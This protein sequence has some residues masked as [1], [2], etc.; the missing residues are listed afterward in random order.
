[1]VSF[2]WQLDIFS[3]HALKS[4]YELEVSAD[5]WRYTKDKPSL[6][7]EATPAFLTLFLLLILLQMSPFSLTLPTSTQPLLPFPL[8]VTALLSVSMGYAYMFFG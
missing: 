7:L 8:A 6:F 3:K 2:K 1:M 4:F 5:H